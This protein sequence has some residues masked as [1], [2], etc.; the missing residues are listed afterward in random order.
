VPAA[1]HV[2]AQQAKVSAAPVSFQDVPMETREMFRAWVADFPA[3]SPSAMRIWEEVRSVDTNAKRVAKITSQD[4]VM[5]ARLLRMA[6]S[7]S[8]AQSQDVTSTEQAILLMG[9][10]CVLAMAIHETMAGLKPFAPGGY[11]LA[12]LMRHGVVTGLLAGVLARHG[13]RVG[14]AEAV[15]VG[16]MHDIGKLVMNASNAP[17]VRQLLDIGSTEVGESLLRKEARLF[18]GN[19]AVVGAMLAT[20][21]RLPAVLAVAI[22][23]H[24]DPAAAELDKHGEQARDLAATVFVA[25]QLA[26]L[27]GWSGND[28]EIDLPPPNMLSTLKLPETYEA[29]SKEVLPE[30][31]TRLKAFGYQK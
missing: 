30:V 16:V 8:T 29:V 20:E 9:Y 7:A 14:S 22:R 12:A 10:D 31:L 25:N 11:D 6:N 5:T 4:P 18:G 28:K 1:V 17:L 2:A 24:H 3:M 26:K 23:F 21:W 27:T 19:H 15:T 13:G